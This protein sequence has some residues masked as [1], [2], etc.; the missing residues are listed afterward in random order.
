MMFLFVALILAVSV[1]AA[2]PTV[3]YAAKNDTI[4]GNDMTATYAFTIF[5]NGGSIER[6]QL[7]T[8]SAFW[9]VDSSSGTIISVS[10]G[11][12]SDF[13]MEIRLNDKQLFGPQLVPV[14][15]KALS[16]GDATV[17]NLYVYVKQS[18]ATIP[19]YVPN[20][21]M[22]VN[23]KDEIDP[24]SSISIDVY[25]R[26][27][28]LLNIKDLKIVIESPLFSKEYSTTL[29][30][31]EEKT[32]QILFVDINKIQQPGNYSVDIRLET[33][34]KTIAQVR[35]DVHVIGYSDVGVEQTTIKG[36]FSYT[37]HLKIY[38]DGNYDATKL[39][40]VE[41]NFFEKLFTS[42]SARYVSLSENGVSY[43]TW[44]VPLKPQETYDI[45]VNTNYTILVIILILIVAGIIMYY[46]FRSPVLL[47]K[48]AKIVSSS[49]DGISEIRVKLHLKNRSGRVI[50][51]IKV[52]DKYP[53]IVSLV[54][55]NSLGTLKPSKMLSADKVHSLLSWNLDS[56]EP[57]EER[58]LSY[59]VRSQLNI[60]GNLSLHPA[61]VRFLSAA[62]ERVYTSNDV[63]LQHKSENIVSYES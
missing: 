10:P 27:R 16:S 29:G 23:M 60:V 17:E 53:K 35:K 63:V 25:M 39:V 41:K 5:N 33:D 37:E 26:N 19:S 32:N 15:I 3:V 55:D 20:V 51:N 31:L 28:N 11:S 56:L 18:N 30:P 9:D 52:I 48:R 62:G 8:I 36:L 47:F 22:D 13:D 59:T 54:E 14:T 38:N 49:D 4:S 12:S 2:T 46:I 50:K 58:L 7:Y 61:K 21:A 43:I 44:T 40:K 45:T 42:T 24:R 6:Y 57:Y 34:N 1:S